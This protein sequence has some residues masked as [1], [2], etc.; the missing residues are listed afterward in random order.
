MYVYVPNSD[1]AWHGIV[2]DD[3]DIVAKAIIMVKIK[4][5]AKDRHVAS[6]DVLAIDKRC[7]G[8]ADMLAVKYGELHAA[9]AHLGGAF[10]RHRE[11][12]RAIHR[13]FLLIFE[14]RQQA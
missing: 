13:M 7:N 1:L 10:N 3:F 12:S 4:G 5:H 6:G 8:K 9:P 2:Q 11:M 14:A